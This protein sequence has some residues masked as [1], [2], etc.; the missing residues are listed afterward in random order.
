[1]QET[2]VITDL[3][4]RMTLSTRN[5]VRWA[6]MA[7]NSTVAHHVSHS[8]SNTLDDIVSITIKMELWV[9][10]KYY[11]TQIYY[12]SVKVTETL[13]RNKHIYIYF[14]FPFRYAT[15]YSFEAPTSECCDPHSLFHQTSSLPWTPTATAL[16]NV[17]CMN[18]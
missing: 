17:V 14:F 10:V 11:T 18:Y 13:K 16:H 4:G 15:P 2:E 6:K 5:C 7:S 3:T 1:M 9:C 8:R 12:F